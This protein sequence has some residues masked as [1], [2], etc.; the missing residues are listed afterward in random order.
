MD[1]R[2]HDGDVLKGVVAGIAGGLVASWVMSEFQ[3]QW[4][5]LA[6]NHRPSSSGGRHDAR[7]W[8]E[9]S[10]DQNATELAAQRI[11]GLTLDRRLTRDELEVAA[12]LV[13]YGFGTVMGAI[14]GGLSEL[15]G[16][17]VTRG[18]AYGTVIWILGDEIAVPAMGLSHAPRSYSADAHAQAFA[19]HVVYGVASDLVRKTIR[20]LL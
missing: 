2:H 20:A 16:G 11:A 3:A 7:E 19:S 8:Q 17:G 12:P 9:R 5:R 14:Y 18:A 13:H 4:T 6:D 15:I 10:E 1:R